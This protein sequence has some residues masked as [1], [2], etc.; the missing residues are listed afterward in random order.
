M[1][2]LQGRLG[3]LSSS[4]TKHSG[5]SHASRDD[6]FDPVYANRVAKM[7]PFDHRH[8]GWS[9]IREAGWLAG[10][11]QRRHPNVAAVALAN[12]NARIVWAM[13]AGNVSYE[14]ARSVQAA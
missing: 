7:S 13:L 4:R 8:S 11:R 9:R 1:M 3:I 14:P 10:L 2:P 12:K 6:Q 5:V